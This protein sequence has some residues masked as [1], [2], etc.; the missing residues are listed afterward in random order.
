LHLFANRVMLTSLT[1]LLLAAILVLS[2]GTF[3]I[4]TQAV[5]L[6][7]TG[8]QYFANGT[9]IAYFDDG[10]TSS[11]EHSITPDNGYYFDNSINFY[12]GEVPGTPSGNGVRCGENAT[13]R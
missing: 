11:F 8:Q 1:A 5:A 7:M 3:A 13:F 12:I 9:G 6:E 4:P 10:T 2:I